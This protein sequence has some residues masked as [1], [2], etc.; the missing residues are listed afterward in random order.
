M[1]IEI[2][3]EIKVQADSLL[4]N[5]RK[6]YINNR[7]LNDDTAKYLQN[8]TII[9]LLL[10][11]EGSL[12]LYGELLSTKGK[13]EYK[14]YFIFNF[15]IEGNIKIYDSE[16][17][18]LSID[19]S[20][21]K[22]SLEWFTSFL[23]TSNNK[24]IAQAKLF[25]SLQLTFVK[26]EKSLKKYCRFDSFFRNL[27]S[28][29]ITKSNSLK[30]GKNSLRTTTSKLT[31][32]LLNKCD[33]RALDNVNKPGRL[34]IFFSTFC[35]KADILFNNYL[36]K[37]LRKNQDQDIINTFKNTNV[38]YMAALYLSEIFEKQINELRDHS[39]IELAKSL[40]QGVVLIFKRDIRRQLNLKEFNIVEYFIETL[41]KKESDIILPDRQL[42]TYCKPKH[43][44]NYWTVA[45]L[46][47]ACPPISLKGDLKNIKE[48][49]YLPS[50]YG[51]RRLTCKESGFS[52]HEISTLYDQFENHFSI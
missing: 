39:I 33:H 41:L 10:S 32:Q 8:L 30:T 2:P 7:R 38:S 51:Y 35:K 4:D 17:L 47:T 45:E 48:S 29:L 9:C 24:F 31:K 14:N 16:H 25:Q 13:R 12:V 42:E 36:N 3:K 11:Q 21:V 1:N 22:A 18:F 27:A 43:K 19:L 40:A 23:E 15:L 46:V 52:S 5:L 28:T 34:Q 6:L 49:H 37:V 20:E 26:L 44:G 50:I